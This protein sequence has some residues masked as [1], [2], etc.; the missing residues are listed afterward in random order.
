MMVS[1][2][3]EKKTY[4]AVITQQCSPFKEFCCGAFF[5]CGK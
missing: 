5:V 3:K 2:E 4:S 1:L